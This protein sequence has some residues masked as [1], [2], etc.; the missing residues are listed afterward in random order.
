[1]TDATNSSAAPDVDNLKLINTELADRLARQST[2]GTQID[3]KAMVLVGYVAAASSFLA[4]QHSELVLAALAYTAYAAAAGFG[5]WAYA[6]RSSEDVPDPRT[7]LNEYADRARID[8][9]TELAATRVEVF[10]SN[11]PELD[12]KAKRWARS[13]TALFIGIALMLAALLT[14]NASHARPAGYSH[15]RP[16]RTEHHSGISGNGRSASVHS[17]AIAAVFSPTPDGTQFFDPDATSA[18]I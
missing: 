4:T 17:E 9:L 8:T 11:Q 7:L 6:V 5:V 2:A 13:L 18:T 1:M 14:H 15:A 3:T 10:E 12:L 16:A